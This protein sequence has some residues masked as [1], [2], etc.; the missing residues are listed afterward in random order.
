MNDE[1]LVPETMPSPQHLMNLCM[2]RRICLR[3]YYL[4]NDRRRK[5]KNIGEGGGLEKSQWIE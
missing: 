2:I 3:L 4:A 1:R 5:T